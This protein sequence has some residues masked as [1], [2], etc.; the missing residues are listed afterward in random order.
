MVEKDRCTFFTKKKKSVFFFK[1]AK[2]MIDL[3]LSNNFFPPFFSLP[4]PP[5]SSSDL[6]SYIQL[7]KKISFYFMV[8]VAAGLS[9]PVPYDLQKKIII[10][11]ANVAGIFTLFRYFLFQ[12]QGFQEKTGHYILLCF[13]PGWLAS[14]SGSVRG[15]P[16]SIT[17]IFIF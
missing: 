16:A 17:T 12:T 2:Y 14:Y 15:V 13:H 7:S 8:P 9:R 6:V 5:R 3:A 4:S 11:D 1:M 10:F